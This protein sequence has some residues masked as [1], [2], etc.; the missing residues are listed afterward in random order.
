MKG[1]N[2]G[3][4]VIICVQQFTSNASAISSRQHKQFYTTRAPKQW[5]MAPTMKH[6]W[7]MQEPRRIIFTLNAFQ[8]SNASRHKT[9][10]SKTASSHAL[11]LSPTHYLLFFLLENERDHP[12]RGW[13]RGVTMLMEK[14]GRTATHAHSL[15]ISIHMCTHTTTILTGP[16]LTHKSPPPP[17]HRSYHLVRT[18]HSPRFILLHNI[19]FSP[20]IKCIMV[21]IC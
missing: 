15:R 11:S 21:R 3:S 19:S 13:L 14:E 7:F 10:V 8:S 5:L 12:Q 1:K 20:P 4:K 16:L 18:C 2:F 9:N 6:S 17:P